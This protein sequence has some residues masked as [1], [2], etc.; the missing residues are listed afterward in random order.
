MNE[1][2]NSDKKLFEKIK[3]TNEVRNLEGHKVFRLILQFKE[4]HLLYYLNYSDFKKEFKFFNQNIPC[5]K[6]NHILRN[7]ILRKIARFSNNTLNSTAAYVEYIR[8]IDQKFDGHQSFKSEK[9][10]I[11][12]QIDTQGIHQLMRAI[13]NYAS[14]ESPVETSHINSYFI[15]EENEHENNQHISLKNPELF[16]K[17]LQENIEKKQIKKQKHE[18]DKIA[19]SYFD[20]LKGNVFLSELFEKYIRFLNKI[21]RNIL[22][23]LLLHHYKQL[24][25]FLD[26]TQQLRKEDMLYNKEIPISTAQERYLKLLLRKVSNISN[27]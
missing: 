17:N 12:S 27:I 14:H 15:N 1:I 6:I 18:Y 11:I 7:R 5:L 24:C 22:Q 8:K 26:K 2:N 19:L 25:E 4:K 20:S 16:R 3:L 13:R 10:E 21:H 9:E 23:S